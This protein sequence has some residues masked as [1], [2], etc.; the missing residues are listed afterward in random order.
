MEFFNK[1]NVII[2]LLL[3][4]VGFMIYIKF[5]YNEKQKKLLYNI[6]DKDNISDYDKPTIINFNTSWCGY[7]QQFQP[8]WDSFTEAMSSKDI[9]IIDMKCDLHENRELC[10]KYYVRGYPTVSLFHDGNRI[11]YDGD[12][13]VKDLTQFLNDNI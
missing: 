1:R 10:D 12:R 7:S 2:L 3:I 9:N 11:D 6:T 13:T 8:I 5:F 4:L